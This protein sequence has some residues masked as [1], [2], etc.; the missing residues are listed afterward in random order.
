MIYLE[1]KHTRFKYLPKSYAYPLIQIKRNYHKFLHE[2][3]PS[4][5]KKY[6]EEFDV[7]YVHHTTA[8]EGN[9]LSLKETGL[10]LDEGVAPGRKELREIHEIENYRRVL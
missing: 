3:Y 6:Q 1:T 7:R 8:I 4:E 5:L 10:V 2:N 9:T